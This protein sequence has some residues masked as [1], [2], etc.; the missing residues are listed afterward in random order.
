MTT[1]FTAAFL[2]AHEPAFTSALDLSRTISERW[3]DGKTS[4][5]LYARLANMILILF[6]LRSE[7]DLTAKQ[8]ECL[9]Y[10]LLALAG[11]TTPTVEC[12]YEEP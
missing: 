11:G 5:D 2:T 6:A 1:I 8:V 12:V 10:D 7:D 3:A 9:E 4:A